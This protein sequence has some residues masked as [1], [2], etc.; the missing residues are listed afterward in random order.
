MRGVHHAKLLLL[1][2]PVLLLLLLLATATYNIVC[3][4]IFS[5]RREAADLSVDHLSSRLFT[6]EPIDLLASTHVEVI[7]LGQRDQRDRLTGL[8]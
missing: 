5:L 4:R 6:R 1:L 8:A 7:Q 3:L 2:L